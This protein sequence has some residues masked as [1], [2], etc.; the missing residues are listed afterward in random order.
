M[1]LWHLRINAVKVAFVLEKTEIV[2][3]DLR[4]G[5]PDT[6]LLLDQKAIPYLGVDGARWLSRTSNPLYPART[7]MGGFDSLTLPPEHCFLEADND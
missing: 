3:N 4:V 1:Q 5:F 2:G 6:V 7:G